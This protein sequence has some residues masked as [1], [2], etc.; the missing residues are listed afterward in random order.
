[1]LVAGKHQ[2]RVLV[3]IEGR[4]GR[5]AVR[6]ISGATGEPPRVSAYPQPSQIFDKD[7]EAR[8]PQK[9]IFAFYVQQ[10]PDTPA[11]K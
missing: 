7:M 3:W 5:K 2:L 8:R 1:M 10:R 6:L 4:A 9:P 11:C